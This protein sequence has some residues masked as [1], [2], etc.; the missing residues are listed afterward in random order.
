[1]AICD[2][3]GLPLAVHVASASPG[4]TT[5]VDA[6]LA[7]RFLRALPTRLIG[8]R[9]YDSDP[10][11]RHLADHF[12]IALIA[13]NRSNRRTRTQDGRPLRRYRR[14]WK[15]ERLFAWFHNSRRIVTRWERD[16]ANFLGMIHLASAVILLRA[17]M[18]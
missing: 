17:F 2:G 14:R 1:M 16:P 13:P 15:I 5:L 18:R 11:D 9:G 12:G 7:Q 4:E 10:L 3:H 6:T 8:D